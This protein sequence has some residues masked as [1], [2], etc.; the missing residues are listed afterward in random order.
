MPQL[1]ATAIAILSITWSLVGGC[2]R[3]NQRTSARVSS[4]G[5][6]AG[7][8]RTQRGRLPL[9]LRRVSFNVFFQGQC[10]SSTRM[11][12]NQRRFGRLRQQSATRDRF[13]GRNVTLD[14]NVYLPMSRVLGNHVFPQPRPHKLAPTMQLLSFWPRTEPFIDDVHQLRARSHR[15][16]RA[17]SADDE[18]LRGWIVNGTATV[19]A[20]I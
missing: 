12:V 9:T 7:C 5:L 14:L 13:I 11:N 10:D 4:P 19:N 16:Q 8:K 17:Y 3:P 15:E 20:G 18:Q 2:G 1:R 6:F